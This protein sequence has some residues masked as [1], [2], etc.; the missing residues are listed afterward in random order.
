MGA[1]VL[2]YAE[3]VGIDFTLMYNNNVA[4]IVQQFLREV[5]IPTI[6]WPARISILNSIQY[7]WDELK[8]RVRRSECIFETLWKS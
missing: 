2:P 4:A 6:D 1:Y 3:S 8:R 7:L 5:G